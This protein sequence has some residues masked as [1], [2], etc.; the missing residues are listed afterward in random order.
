MGGLDDALGALALGH[1]AEIQGLGREVQGGAQL[2]AIDVFTGK[3]L[4][5]QT[6]IAIDIGKLDGVNLASACQEVERQRGN[7]VQQGLHDRLESRAAAGAELID[8]ASLGGLIVRAG[9][10]LGQRFQIRRN[11]QVGWGDVPGL[12]VETLLFA[13]QRAQAAERLEREYRGCAFHQVCV[14]TMK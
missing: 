14:V 10:L 1:A 12:L 6:F 11:Q 9:E 7:R 2:H 4:R 8:I 5:L 13:H 3:R